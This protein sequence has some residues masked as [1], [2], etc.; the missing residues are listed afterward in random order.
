LGEVSDVLLTVLRDTSFPG[1]HGEEEDWMSLPLLFGDKLQGQDY[2]SLP[3]EEADL[4]IGEEE[5]LDRQGELEFVQ[6]KHG[7]VLLREDSFDDD[8]FDLA[9]GERESL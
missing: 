7:K 2:V 9:L 4:R 5:V 1:N 6:L 3:A 8:H